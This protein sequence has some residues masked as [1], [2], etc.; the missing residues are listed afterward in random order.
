MTEL[1][2]VYS[3]FSPLDRR[4]INILKGIT[5]SIRLT[6]RRIVKI[7]K[8]CLKGLDLNDL[9]SSGKYG[10]VYTS[11]CSHNEKKGKEEYI[12]KYAVKV[13]AYGRDF[14]NEVKGLNNMAKLNIGPTYFGSWSCLD[15]KI[16][17]IVTEIYDTTYFD[18]YR[19]KA[20]RINSDG[21]YE[22]NK[23]MIPTDTF[24]ETI[25]GQIKDMHDNGYLHQDLHSQNI[26]V[27][28][29]KSGSIKKSTI[30]DFGKMIPIKYALKPSYRSEL[31]RNYEHMMRLYPSFFVEKD[32]IGFNDIVKD[33]VVDIE[34]LKLMDYA[35][36]YSEGYLKSLSEFEKRQRKE[37]LGSFMTGSVDSDVSNVGE[38]TVSWFRGTGS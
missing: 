1:G 21:R 10:V 23:G 14:I 36:V 34:K 37:D 4:E 26:L 11:G 27:K 13:Q 31:I 18:F 24:Y 2:D 35:A 17:I 22:L 6:D 25:L 32:I 28:I 16:G 3:L 9:I 30:T 20:Q 19:T 8:Y 5:K 38:K 33:D 29:D 12:C 7:S 15:R